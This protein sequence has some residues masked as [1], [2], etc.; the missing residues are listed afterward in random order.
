MIAIELMAA[1][2]AID[3][4]KA[5]ARQRNSGG[6]HDAVREYV[7]HLEEDR[8]LYKDITKIVRGC[9]DWRNTEWC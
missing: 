1:A 4:Q 3:F 9:G 6:T 7:E 8:P 2:Q 5:E